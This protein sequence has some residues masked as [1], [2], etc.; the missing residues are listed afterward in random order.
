MLNLPEREVDIL[1]SGSRFR[2]LRTHMH[3]LS[4]PRMSCYSVL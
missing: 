3:F 2:M 4:A 1:T